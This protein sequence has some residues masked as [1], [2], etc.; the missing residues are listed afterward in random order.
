MKKQFITIGFITA[1]CSAAAFFLF[2]RTADISAQVVMAICF[3]I[4]VPQLFT[5]W[6]FLTSLGIFKKEL[7]KAYR[8]LALSALL[9]GLARLPLPLTS[10]ITI[11]P[12]IWS[13]FVTISMLLGGLLMYTSVH[14]FATLLELRSRF[15][16]SFIVVTGFALL[17]AF[18][19]SF[20][21]HMAYPVSEMLLDSIFGVYVA[22]GS[23][24]LAS[25][26]LTWRIKYK[27]GPSYRTAMNWLVAASL[28]LMFAAYHETLLRLLP[29]FNQESFLWYSGY[30][31]SLWPLLL[32]AFC[33]LG[34]G[35]SFRKLNKELADLPENASHLDVINYV[36]QLVSN[37]LAID[38]SLDKVRQITAR[39]GS[40]DNLSAADQAIVVTVYKE[41]E[42]YLINK[43]PLRKITK[44]DL[45]AR[46]PHSFRKAV[47]GRTGQNVT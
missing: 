42:A 5:I 44:E 19:S 38:V 39:Q 11:D 29:V 7:K 40:A 43:E 26:A 46:L 30:G 20:I 34:A 31:V 32:V 15:W 3:A 16:G 6:A 45:R 9:L 1:V 24:A 12:I 28:A 14:A 21:P 35:L 8:M 33:F 13:W 36:A 22:A 4:F 17:M 10:F 18:A 47:E 2:P 41:I 37:P 23:F 27:L 25:A